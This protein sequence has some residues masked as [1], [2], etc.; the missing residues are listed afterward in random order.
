MSASRSRPESSGHGVISGE[1]KFLCFGTYMHHCM[2]HGQC[3]WGAAM[4]PVHHPRSVECLGMSHGE[5]MK[6]S[7]RALCDGGDGGSRPKPFGG[8]V[9]R[10]CVKGAG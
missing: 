7:S 3:R 8:K 4:E 10:A 5:R 2:R 9:Q 1:Y 6:Q